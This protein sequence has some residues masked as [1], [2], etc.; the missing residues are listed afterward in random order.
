MN[1]AKLKNLKLQGETGHLAENI[2]QNW[3]IG[4]RETNPAI[5]AMFRD[6][7]LT[8]YRDLLPWSGEFAGKYLTSCYYVYRLTR[9]EELY[10]YVCRF[11]DELLTFQDIDG[12]LGCFAK[13]CRLTGAYSQ[14]PSRIGFTWDSWSHYHIMFGL[15]LW[16][17]LTNNEE[18]FRAVE[19][20]AELFMKKFYDGKPTLV[21][22][23]SSEM[24][25]AVYHV[26]GLLYRRTNNPDYLYFAK[27]I[28]G[29]LSDKEAGDYINYSLK[30]YEYYQCPKPR[31]ESMHII[32]GIAEMYRNTGNRK[33]LDVA[34][35]IFYSILKT[36]V[37]NTGAFSTDEQAIGNP[38]KNSN[39]ETCCVV[40]Y[41]ALGIE[42]YSLTGDIKVAD[43]LERS[44]YNAV[45]GYNNPSGRWSTYNTPMDGAKCANYHSIN[46][47]CRPGSPDLNCCS[48][49]APRGVASVYDWMLT[50]QDGDLCINFYEDLHAETESGITVDIRGGYPASG[51]IAVS[52]DSK[53]ER[54]KIVFRIPEWSK[55]TVIIS[56]GEI[57]RPVAGKYFAIKKVWDSEISI[58]F[59]FTPYTENGGHDTSDL[60]RADGIPT[61]FSGEENI[62]YSNKKS[63][64]VGPVLYGFDNGDNPTVD[65]YSIPVIRRQELLSAKP[66]LQPDGSIHLTVGDMVLT[67]FYH[68]GVSGSN[69]KTW[70]AVED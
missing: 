55:N 25:L 48:V 7:D 39:I 53:G 17:D 5:L 41:N 58:D 28:E 4:I 49:N 12:Y 32:M 46:F 20:T 45:L 56:D 42:I 33:Y 6:R 40:A 27:K 16:Y 70:L 61:P 68:L 18:Y 8:P 51:K 26:F 50:E 10:E 59:D 14:D 29:D 47:Q 52:I 1:T 30:G 36:D 22:I 60:E 35:Q 63:I 24:N 44:H 19:K 43:F 62:D 2:A 21:S 64:Y 54:K 23:G 38:F 11:I 9:D 34:T 57:F 15:L 66:A 13:D 67:D 3:L 31:W 65:F 37:H 69:Y